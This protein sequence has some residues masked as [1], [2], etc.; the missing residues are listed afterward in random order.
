MGCARRWLGGLFTM[1][2]KAGVEPLALW[3]A[4]RDPPFDGGPKRG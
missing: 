1:W 4:V 3:E 2:I